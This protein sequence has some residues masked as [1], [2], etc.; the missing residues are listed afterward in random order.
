LPPQILDYFDYHRTMIGY[1]G[2]DRASADRLVCGEPFKV[3]D[4]D[5]EWFGQGMNL[6][7]HAYQQASWLAREH[8]RIR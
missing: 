8:I 3:G 2:A 6:W 1:H 5:N 7:K 4:E